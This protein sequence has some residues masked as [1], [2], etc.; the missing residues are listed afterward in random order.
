MCQRGRRNAADPAPPRLP[1]QPT[2]AGAVSARLPSAP[3]SEQYPGGDLQHA[4]GGQ[5]DG[6]AVGGLARLSGRMT[7]LRGSRLADAETHRLGLL[8]VFGLLG[9]VM[10][11]LDIPQRAITPGQASVFYQD[12]LVVGGGWIAR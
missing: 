7:A 3:P 6:A 8:V 2:P 4:Q 12:D 10:R 5:P 11:K 9:Y 1:S